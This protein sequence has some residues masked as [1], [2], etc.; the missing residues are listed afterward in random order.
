MKYLVSF[1]I[2]LFA[3]LPFTSAFCQTKNTKGL[4]LA[5]QWILSSFQEN[6]TAQAPLTKSSYITI[7]EKETKFG[8]NGGCNVISGVVK[9][10]KNK[11]KFEKISST[12]MACEYL[13]QE[14]KFLAALEAATNFEISGCELYLFKGKQ[15][16][17]T[18]ESCR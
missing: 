7:E 8:G 17:L 12:R 4:P 13:E 5:N 18:L 3:M 11:I 1:S 2:Y 9:R 6:G 16:L 14:R 15:K 10:S